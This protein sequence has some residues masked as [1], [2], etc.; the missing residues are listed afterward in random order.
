M[1]EGNRFSMIEAIAVLE[2][3]A[4]VEVLFRNKKDWR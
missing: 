4:L 3:F 1:I 2:S